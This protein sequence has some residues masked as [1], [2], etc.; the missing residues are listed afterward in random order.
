[1]VTVLRPALVLLV[2]LLGLA[3]RTRASVPPRRRHWSGRARSGDLLWVALGDSLTQGTG[4]TR[5]GT[6]WLGRCVDAAEVRTGRTVRVV[7]LAVYGARVDDVLA[8]QLPAAQQL[9]VPLAQAHV[10]TLCVGS[11]DA[12]RLT[13]AE[14][15]TRLEQL[16]DALPAGAVVGDVPEFQ[17]GPRVAAAAELSAVVR[18][19]VAARPHLVLAPVEHATAGTRILTELAGDFFHPNDAGHA[20][21]ARAF[22]P[23]ALRRMD[24][25]S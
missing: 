9:A 15:R 19:V 23:A 10:V 14:F 13:P 20:R 11:N 24:Q 25:I 1:L 22:A 2:A 7:N 21:I 4:S 5:P 8:L 18:D 3:L 17:W 6:S 16:C 12:G